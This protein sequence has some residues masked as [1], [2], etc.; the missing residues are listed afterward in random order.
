[1]WRDTRDYSHV[2]SNSRDPW[3][4]V[5]PGGCRAEPEL[6]I[7][8]FVVTSTRSSVFLSSSQLNNV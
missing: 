6:D 8:D 3:C 1:M 4:L 5:A 2:I 7:K